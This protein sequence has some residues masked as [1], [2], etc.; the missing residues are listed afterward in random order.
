MTDFKKVLGRVDIQLLRTFLLNG[1]GVAGE[2][3]VRSYEQR[4]RKDERPIYELLEQLYER[5]LEEAAEHLRLALETTQEMFLEI[6][7]KAGARF[8]FQLLQDERHE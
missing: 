1:V 3:D 8:L 4:I 5:E 7:M 6:G 2:Q